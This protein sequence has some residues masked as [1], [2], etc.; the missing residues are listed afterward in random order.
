MLINKSV[1]IL[2]LLL[3]NKKAE[4]ITIINVEKYNNI[5]IYMIICTAISNIHA[6][7]LG[8]DLIKYAKKNKIKI[9]GKE[10]QNDWIL[11][12]LVDIV[13]HIMLKDVRSFY[14][15]EQLWNK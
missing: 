7:S 5:M 12:D 3:E 2:K 15:L 11:V 9:F 6:K 1:N 13:I 14:N 8:N 4:E 10:G